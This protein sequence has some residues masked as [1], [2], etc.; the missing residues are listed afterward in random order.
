MESAVGFGAL[1]LGLAAIEGRENLFMPVIGPMVE[2]SAMGRDA[3]KMEG[4]GEG[5]PIMPASTS[6]LLVVDAARAPVEY[7]GVRIGVWMGV[8]AKGT[9]LPLL[10]PRNASNRT[11]GLYDPVVGM[12]ISVGKLKPP[13]LVVEGGS[14]V[15]KVFGLPNI[16][17]A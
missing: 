16:E 17:P 5:A 1:A 2:G 4:P 8:R 7:V 10:D 3:P 12:V 11:D 15:S 13:I 14:T 9:S 6:A